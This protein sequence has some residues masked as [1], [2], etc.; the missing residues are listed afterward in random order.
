L[1]VSNR[2]YFAAVRLVDLGGGGLVVSLSLASLAAIGCGSS[3]GAKGVGAI[4][5]DD[6]GTG[7]TSGDNGGGSWATADGGGVA[8]PSAG[9]APTTAARPDSVKYV[10]GVT[11]TTVAGGASA[12][13][14]TNPVGVVIEPSGSF[15][16]SDFDDNLL[17]R[18]AATGGA[19]TPLTSQANFTRPYALAY[20]GK[21]GILYAQTDADPSGHHDHETTATIWT[22]DRGSGAAT[23][24]WPDVGDTRG[25]GVLSD[26]R[27]VLAD[28]AHQV[29]WLVDPTAGTHQV[30]AGSLDCVGGADGTGSTATFTTPYGL[31]VLPDD[32]IVVADYGLRTLRKVTT[33]GVV[34]TLAGDGGPAGTIDGPGSSARFVNPQAVAADATGVVYV[35]DIGA[36]RIRRV[37]TDGT[38]MTL[39]G[40]GTADFADGAGNVADFYGGEGLAVSADGKTV[41]VADGTAGSDTPGPY[42]RLRAITIGQ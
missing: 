27:V 19:I 12:A 35:S 21:R 38:V 15:L 17:V 39:A 36:H 11:V 34:T 24:L 41:Y 9:A 37:G 14:I 30:L 5:D 4:G 16:V 32:S 29:I 10:V 6:G 1:S 42:H 20:D 8:C 13:N 40:S 33:A 31:A 3:G 7:S 23:A 22:V 28:R 26:G 18:A 2:Y 25:M